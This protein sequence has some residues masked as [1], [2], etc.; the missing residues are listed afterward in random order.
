MGRRMVDYEVV[1]LGV[2]V[3]NW[4]RYELICKSCGG[5][6]Q[7]DLEDIGAMAMVYCRACKGWMGR[8]ARVNLDA[9]NKARAAGSSLDLDRLR[10]EIRAFT[11]FARQGGRRD[12]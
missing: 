1:L 3:D 11:E 6:E 4:P 7:D 5:Y 8:R 12:S 10:E 9:W 2:V